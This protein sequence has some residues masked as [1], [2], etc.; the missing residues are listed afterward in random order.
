MV[1]YDVSSRQKMLADLKEK[2]LKPASSPKPVT[3]PC[4]PPKYQVVQ[5]RCES[6]LLTQSQSISKAT[7]NHDALFTF[8][9]NVT[10]AARK[11][12]NPKVQGPQLIVTSTSG[13]PL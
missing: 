3:A 9:A 13:V 2:N 4:Q 12:G 11:T 1:N 6:P 7:T 10:T 5:P 8:K